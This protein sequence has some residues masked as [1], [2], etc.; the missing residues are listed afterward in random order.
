MKSN[1]PK[2]AILLQIEAQH[3]AGLLPH[4]APMEKEAR[5]GFTRRALAHLRSLSRN[6]AATGT[7]TPS[8]A[9]AYKHW[10]CNAN[11]GKS[12][13]QAPEWCRPQH[14]P[15][16]WHALHQ[17]GLTGLPVATARAVIIAEAEARTDWRE[18]TLDEE[19]ADLI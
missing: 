10:W 4:R 9:N 16:L 13:A 5:R 19:I 7:G 1:E 8:D 12:Y 11:P 15:V 6:A 14:D 2:R 17:L 18:Q 3:C